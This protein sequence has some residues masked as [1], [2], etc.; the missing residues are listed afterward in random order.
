MAIICA[1]T[2]KNGRVNGRNGARKRTDHDS[3]QANPLHGRGACGGESMQRHLAKACYDAQRRHPSKADRAVLSQTVANDEEG[4]SH[5]R[6]RPVQ[7]AHGGAWLGRDT[8]AFPLPTFFRCSRQ[9][10]HGPTT[11]EPKKVGVVGVH[12]RCTY[13]GRPSQTGLAAVSQPAWPTEVDALV[14][15]L[16]G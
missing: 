10:V 6:E 11:R 12:V 1:H 2:C 9:R 14:Q 16:I 7:R 8:A 4:Q 5:A 15:T 3:K 13:E